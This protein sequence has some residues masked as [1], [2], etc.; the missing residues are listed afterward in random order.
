MGALCAT[1]WRGP[2]SQYVGAD[3]LICTDA[4][5]NGNGQVCAN[6]TGDHENRVTDYTNII[7]YGGDKAGTLDASYY[8]GA[9][10]RVYDRVRQASGA[11]RLLGNSSPQG[12]YDRRR[13]RL[14]GKST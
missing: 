2:N 8:K 5:G 14:L 13:S 7:T 9:G 4:R 12:R 6:V 11:A 3:K 1:D 10:A